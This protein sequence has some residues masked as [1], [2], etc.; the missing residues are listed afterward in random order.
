MIKRL[1]L[2]LLIIVATAVVLLDSANSDRASSA[3]SM[4]ASEADTTPQLSPAELERQQQIHQEET[5]RRIAEMDRGTQQRKELSDEELHHHSIALQ[6]QT[7]EQQAWSEVL[8]TNWQ[9]YL[10]LKTA[11]INATNHTAPCTICNGR[12]SMDFC[13][14][15]KGSGA[16]LVCGGSGRGAFGQRCAACR[17]TGK[18]YLCRGSAKMPCL[19]CDDGLVYAKA[20]PP[21][22][23]MP[24]PQLN[25]PEPA[26]QVAAA[27]N[28][29]PA[30]APQ[31]TGQPSTT[32]ASDPAAQSAQSGDTTAA[33][34]DSEDAGFLSSALIVPL[35]VFLVLLG[36]SLVLLPKL[37]S[38]LNRRS[39]PWRTFD[40][41]PEESA[42]AVAN[43]LLP[44]APL[45]Y[46]PPVASVTDPALMRQNAL[47]TFFDVTSD[48]VAAVQSLFKKLGP[49]NDQ[50][51]NQEIYRQI[52]QRLRPIQIVADHPELV[53]IAKLVTA[54]QWLFEQ[55]AADSNKLNASALKT[56]AQAILVM[57]SYC[58]RREACPLTLSSPPR[59]LVVDDDPICR[60]ALA[61]ALKKTLNTPDFADDGVLAVSLAVNKTFDLIFLDIEMPGMNGYDACL[62]IHQTQRNR[63]T[64]VVFVTSHSD[65]ESRTLSAAAGGRDFIAKPF[66]S[67]EVTVKALSIL[68]RRRLDLHAP[69]D[70][71]ASQPSRH[72]NSPPITRA[73][74][75]A[76]A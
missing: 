69:S 58:S 13:I 60:M 61:S 38:W 45:C 63:D 72:L 27:E 12:G 70:A 17:G 59:F 68:I 33:T 14:I 9:A 6:L 35:L 15:C 42:K 36:A 5:S 8:K 37:A 55:I 10:S 52:A 7:S 26:P 50:P 30:P 3:R 41:W 71:S 67:S 40:Y 74:E 21:P 54:L 31:T 24:V 16:C 28:W 22:A 62:N 49:S 75:K 76:A 66:L 57:A 51:R 64:P 65:F 34:T 47:R 20:K 29:L 32:S 53:L 4:A 23:Q 43:P 46:F 18:C 2:L 25:R 48:S 1:A 11:A 73:S 19:F 44:P 39:D 56:A